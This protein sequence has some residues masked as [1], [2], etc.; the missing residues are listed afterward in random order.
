[1]KSGPLAELFPQDHETRAVI[2]IA[3]IV[4]KFPTP[5]MLERL[6]K[7]LAAYDTKYA[8]QRMNNLLTAL[9]EMGVQIGDY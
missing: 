5:P 4:F 6:G 8:T 1:M 3:H 7:A 9:D 2:A